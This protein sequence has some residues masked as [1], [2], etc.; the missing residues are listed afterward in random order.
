MKTST[1]KNFALY[2]SGVIFIIVLW[3]VLALVIKND[4]VIPNISSVFKSLINILKKGN[5]YLIILN[6]IYRLIL[7]LIIGF[8]VSLILALLSYVFKWFSDFISPLIALMRMIPVT[9]III[10]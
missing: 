10:I 8:F 3:E 7:S 9:T 1:I 5:T 6:T 2:I 4:L